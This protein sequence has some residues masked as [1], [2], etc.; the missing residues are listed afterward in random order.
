MANTMTQSH[1]SR[2]RVRRLAKLSLSLSLDFS[3]RTA[4]ISLGLLWAMMTAGDDDDDEESDDEEAEDLSSVIHAISGRT[5][6]DVVQELASDLS[7]RGESLPY[8]AHRRTS[9]P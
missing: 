6:Y 8:T 4:G 3:F 7:A 5:V 9:Q 2:T 1:R